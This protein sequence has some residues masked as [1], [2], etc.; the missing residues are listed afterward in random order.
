MRL[1][2]LRARIAEI[3]DELRAIHTEAGDAALTDEQQTRWDELET[4]RATRV[5]E[6][7]Q[8]Q[9]REAA[10]VRA[11]QNPRNT[12]HADRD[13][14]ADPR[15]SDPTRGR[16]NPWDLSAVDVPGR[17]HY[18]VGLELRARALDAAERMPAMTDA[19][20]AALTDILE[21][22]DTDRGDLAR[23]VL[24]A[25]DPAYLRAFAKGLRNELYALDDEER[26]AMQRASTLVRAM[27]LTDNAGGYLIPQQLDPTLILTSDGSTN[28]IREISR[29]VVAT[30]DVWYGVSTTHATWSWDAE[31]AEVSDDATVFAQ[32]SIPNHKGA[33]FIPISI[34]ALA[35]ERNVTEAIGT[36]LA[37]GKDDLEAAAFATGTGTGQP[38]G[39]VTAIVAS[40][41]S[42][43]VASAGADTFAVGDLYAVE[44]ALPAK[45][46]TRAQWV[47]NKTIYNDVRQFG[48]SD[49]HALWE[50]LGAGQPARLLGYPTHEA[51]AMD[52][53]IT[54][55]AENY[56][57]LFGDFSNYV[58][59]D[60]LGMVVESIPHLFGASG[61][62]TGQR[63][64]YAYYRTGADSVNDGGFRLLNVT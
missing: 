61:R 47:A 38:T 57:L 30:G 41:P 37:M 27:S 36:V 6:S 60:R 53:S 17:S 15:D 51:S 14:V 19:R 43:L 23:Q 9:R 10:L 2:E 42:R 49:S 62:P 55:A 34:E 1:E 59:T 18:Q 32:P 58:I 35:D 33:G 64:F 44:E 16:G 46:R 5:T 48:T 24:V 25:S 20:R 8:R 13:P 26:A 7:E 50:R 3:D 22:F 31:A 45:Y 54:A 11:A 56:V 29:K 52:G 12:E 21:R 28:P 4:E 63:G 39:I 40:S